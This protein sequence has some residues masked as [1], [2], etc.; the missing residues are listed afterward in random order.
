MPLTSLGSLL[1]RRPVIRCHQ[2]VAQGLQ[3]Q[4]APGSGRVWQGLAGSGRV[5]R[6]GIAGC[7]VWSGMMTE[8][9]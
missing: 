1:T 7:E 4:Q 3:H 8:R 5:L 2:A 9:F 6:L